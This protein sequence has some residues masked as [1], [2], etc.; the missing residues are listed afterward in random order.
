MFRVAFS[1]SFEELVL[2]LALRI[3]IY[4]FFVE[5]EFLL[6]HKIA[7]P[8]AMIVSTGRLPNSHRRLL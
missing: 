6:C 1:A 8:P 2:R 4:V 5:L 7:S 3:G